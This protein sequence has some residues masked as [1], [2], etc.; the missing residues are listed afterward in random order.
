L[1]A[2]GNPGVQD[3]SKRGL[4]TFLADHE[5]CG[6]GFE[7]QR[8][9]GSEESIVR[10]VC[11]GCGKAIEYLAAADTELP[12]EA[13]AG[14]RV[15]QRFLNRERR[16]ATRTGAAAPS[17]GS[18]VDAPST[19]VPSAADAEASEPGV[20][21]M[22]WPRWLPMP[23]IL[24]LIGG[25]L[26][27][28]VLG[29]ASNSGTSDSTP[30]PADATA[31]PPPL[32]TP[33]PAPPA[34]EA[35]RPVRLDRRSFAERVSIGIPE[36]WSAGVSGGAVT[37]AALSGRSEIQ[38]YFE[39]AATSLAQLRRQARTFLL[40]RHPGA[41]VADIGQVDIGWRRAPAIRVAYPTGSESAVV[42][43]AGGYTYLILERLSKP[44]SMSLQRTSDAVVTSFRPT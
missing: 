20:P 41:R 10:V 24:A 32:T 21:S 40:Q 19:G 4:S 36:G 38:V 13:P 33:A 27:L 15:S 17:S 37:I 35:A 34:K 42:L 8:R 5:G 9:Q 30:G 16:S 44:L 22:N 43:V 14:R 2:V 18:G 28:I 1:T 31:G 26:V 29:V 11:G 25:G 12:A 23:L 6:G 7:I 39:H 3:P